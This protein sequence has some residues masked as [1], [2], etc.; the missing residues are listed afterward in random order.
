MVPD[1]VFRLI[2]L[3]V[4]ND[5]KN[6]LIENYA[7]A[8]SSGLTLFEAIVTQK[9]KL[10]VLLAGMSEP[11]TVMENL[12]VGFFQATTGHRGGHSEDMIEGA[13]QSRKLEMDPSVKR[14]GFS[15]A[16]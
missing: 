16:F 8:T 1:G 3:A 5:G 4:L 10:K 6:Y 2:P 15:S 12:P 13:I 7:I 9:R 11:G 14:F